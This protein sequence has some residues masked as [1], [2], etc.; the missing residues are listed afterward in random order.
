MSILAHLP[1]SKAAELKKLATPPEGWISTYD[2]A[3]AFIWQ[4]LT[5]VR[6]PHYQSDPASTPYFGEAINM[7]PRIH[8]PD[9][10]PRFM[11]N[12]LAGGFSPTAPV[13]PPTVDELVSRPLAATAA[14]VRALTSS[15]TAA[16]VEGLMGVIAPIRD[17]RTISLDLKSLAPLS[18]WVTSHREADPSGYDFG[19]GKPKT[20]RC[21]WAGD[22]NNGLVTVYPAISTD[23]PDEGWSISICM[24]KELVPKLLEDPEWTRFIEYRGID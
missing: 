3:S 17:K 19:F 21:F 18:I 20:H 11:R 24:E 23:R 15:V 16:H 8:D 14:Y 6:A 22:M 7:R 12:A 2:A 1:K 5:K 13:R 10:P 4:Q 9:L